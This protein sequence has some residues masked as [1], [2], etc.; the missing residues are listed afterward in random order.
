M[1][2]V[3]YDWWKDHQPQPAANPKVVLG[4]EISGPPIEIDLDKLLSGRLLIQGPSGSGKSTLLRRLISQCDQF[5]QWVLVDPEGEAANQKLKLAL[6]RSAPLVQRQQHAKGAFDAL[7]TRQENLSHVRDI[8]E[9]SR[10]QQLVYLADYIQGLVN[11]P[12]ELW[13]KRLLVIIDEVEIFT[14]SDT[15]A[16]DDPGVGK[17]SRSALVEIM[18]R[19]RKRGLITVVATHRLAQLAASVRAEARNLLIGGSSFDVDI[20]RAAGILGWTQ[21]RAEEII[22]HLPVGCFICCGPAFS[23]SPAIVRIP[24]S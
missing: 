1:L 12:R 11:V 18:T 15:T 9:M 14:P 20:N 13:S 21:R 6:G 4:D 8:S 3:R 7:W 10:E 19:G 2:Q 24:N 16:F 23:K 17:R 22:P 5:L